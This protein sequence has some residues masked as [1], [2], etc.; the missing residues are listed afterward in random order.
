MA[1]AANPVSMWAG[2]LAGWLRRPPETLMS[3]IRDHRAKQ[4]PRT[5]SIYLVHVDFKVS[6][7]YRAD[8]AANLAEI[9]AKYGLDFLILEPGV[10]IKRFDDV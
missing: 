7:E 4:R 1:A 10:T 3:L 9:R 6:S 2:R 5:S 8:F